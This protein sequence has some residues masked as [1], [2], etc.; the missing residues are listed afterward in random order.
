MDDTKKALVITTDTV[1]KKGH[2]DMVD[3]KKEKKPNVVKES[4]T[5]PISGKKNDTVNITE[6]PQASN[7]TVDTPRRNKTDKVKSIDKSRSTKITD[8]ENTVDKSRYIPRTKL[9][10]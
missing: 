5:P 3:K 7:K 2:T 4:I 10:N 1:F 9:S 6:K 8:T